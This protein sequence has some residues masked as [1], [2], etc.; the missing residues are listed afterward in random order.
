MS[1]RVQS[2]CRAIGF[3][4]RVAV[5]FEHRT[6]PHDF[7]G[8]SASRGRFGFQWITVETVSYD[9]DKVPCE[10]RQLEAFLR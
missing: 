5:A 3:M 10:D 4:A 6:Q 9:R 1:W 8:Q 7:V 2:A